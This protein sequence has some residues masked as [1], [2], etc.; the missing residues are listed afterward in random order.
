MTFSTGFG[1]NASFSVNFLDSD[2]SVS[3]AADAY[4]DLPRIAVDVVQVTDVDSQCNTGP[5]S[6]HHFTDGDV[7]NII[8][9]VVFDAGF[10]ASAQAQFADLYTFSP[11]QATYAPLSTSFSLVCLSAI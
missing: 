6:E 2:V 11:A 3:A 7:I 4:F 10:D 8:P 9:S 5:S 1:Y